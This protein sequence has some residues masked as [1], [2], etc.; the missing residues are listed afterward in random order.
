MQEANRIDWSLAFKGYQHITE[1]CSKDNLVSRT[2]EFIEM[3]CSAHNADVAL[4]I[5]SSDSFT[6]YSKNGKSETTEDH[7]IEFLP[8]LYDSLP[9]TRFDEQE[10]AKAK[11]SFPCFSNLNLADGYY[12]SFRVDSNESMWI[13]LFNEESRGVFSSS[14]VLLGEGAAEIVEQFFILSQL[15]EQGGNLLTA[16]QG[17]KNNNRFGL[18]HSIG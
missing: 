8:L 14:D 4:V 3:V 13:L 17:Q 12:Y 11:V 18:S 5:Q 16:L 15:G 2:D 10:L 1:L 9:L 6:V 7:L